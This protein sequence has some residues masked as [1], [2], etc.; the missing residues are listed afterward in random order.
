MPLIPA[1][2][3]QR[4]K[5]ICEFKI[6]LVYCVS[7]RTAKPTTVKAYLKKKKKK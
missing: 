4:R 5:D 1:P 7:S 6:S 3:I 2:G